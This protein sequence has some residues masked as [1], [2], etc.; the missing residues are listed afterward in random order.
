MKLLSTAALFLFVLQFSAPAVAQQSG[1]EI[2]GQV[3]SSR[4]NQPLAL[5]QIQL[6]GAPFRAVT[7]SE[8][9]FRIT[10]VP[11]G[12]Y[13]LQASSVGYYVL[14]QEFTVTAG[15]TKNLLRV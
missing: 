1:G 12:S 2:L 14:R 3:V 6:Q 4:D 7:D 5:V 13:V 11:A 8:G 10:G 15:E 9:R